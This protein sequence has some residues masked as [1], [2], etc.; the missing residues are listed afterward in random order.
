MCAALK[1]RN[2]C[3]R[4]DFNQKTFFI[5]T[6]SPMSPQMSPSSPFNHGQFFFPRHMM[7]STSASTSAYSSPRHSFR[8]RR[9][10]LNSFGSYAEEND[11]EDESEIQQDQEWIDWENHY[12][13]REQLE[14]FSGRV[15]QP[16]KKKNKNS[17]SNQK[18]NQKP[19]SDSAQ[20]K[21]KITSF[22]ISALQY[23]ID[24][25]R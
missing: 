25:L 9:R 17:E 5:F 22:V 2:F 24:T 7:P 4:H 16:K 12:Q 3:I 8:V 19:K 14:E 21:S 1:S 23:V 20:S 11:A 15:P 10:R 18:S 13:H 6:G